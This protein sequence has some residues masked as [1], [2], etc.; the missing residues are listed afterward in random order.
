MFLLLCKLL[1]VL[2]RFFPL[3]SLPRFL[4]PCRLQCMTVWLQSVNVFLLSLVDFS[5]VDHLYRT[6]CSSAFLCNSG[7]LSCTHS[8]QRMPCVHLC[9][10]DLFT[11]NY[12]I[13]A[14]NIRQVAPKGWETWLIETEQCLVEGQHSAILWKDCSTLHGE[15]QALHTSIPLAYVQRPDSS[16]F[17][18]NSAAAE[19]AG[20]LRQ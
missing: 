20:V 5:C 14:N 8:H 13:L 19:I 17:I 3:F 15:A 1:C 16:P 10:V 9:A 12:K 6:L 11:N 4:A 2:P 18:L 7:L